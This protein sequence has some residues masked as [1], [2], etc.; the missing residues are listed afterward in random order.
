M[1]WLRISR[2]SSEVKVIFLSYV[3]E[4]EQSSVFEDG[5]NAIWKE[6]SEHVTQNMIPVSIKPVY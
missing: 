4:I 5:S 6:G 3:V 1:D 2:G